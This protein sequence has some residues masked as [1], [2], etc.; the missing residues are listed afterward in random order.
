[1]AGQGK[2]PPSEPPLIETA[3]IPDDGSDTSQVLNHIFFKAGR[4]SL[5]DTILSGF[6]HAKTQWIDRLYPIDKFVSI[7]KK[8]GVTTE[9][10]KNPLI[11]SYLLE[12][13]AGKADAFI[14]QGTFGR[15]FWKTVKGKTVPNFKGESLTKIL[16][17]VKQP[18]KWRDFSAYLT[19]KHSLELKSIGFETGIPQDVA[20][21]AVAELEAKY[22]HFSELSGKIYKYNSELL[23]YLQESGLL[24]KD[25]RTALEAKY[26]MYV[27]FYRVMEELQTQGY[28]G[29]K[30]VD[31]PSQ[32]KRMQGSERTI[33]NPLE[34][35][36]KNTYTMISAADRNQI[37][38]LMAN[39]ADQ[40]PALA[41]E[42]QHI[43][44]PMAK[45]AQV[46]AKDLGID[47]AG[48]SAEDTEKV[49]DIFRPS[50]RTAE[51]VVTVMID[52]KKQFFRVPDPDLRNALLSVNKT[53]WGVIGKILT[54][55]TKWLRAGATLSPDFIM[56]NPLR[57]QFS[58]FI[59]SKYGFIPGV[60]FFHG[61]AGQRKRGIPLSP[62]T[63]GV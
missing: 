30:M 17:S 41:T 22:P 40:V 55:P 18:D 5:K 8:A 46:T 31:I 42:F 1:M 43:K 50:M 7:A 61:L 47:L 59:Y 57:D 51:D 37:G 39:L 53:D 36:V 16:E 9:L 26:Q 32:I 3:P 33:I 20:N 14:E 23:D 6:N 52:G 28:R 54:Y 15:N 35:I 63:P 13:V 29:K 12:G 24:S 19:A 4:T 10:N 38:I 60:D 56:R 25:L 45:V 48:L 27:P 11:Q 49:F 34:N 21:R 2:P 58:A 62:G 44:T